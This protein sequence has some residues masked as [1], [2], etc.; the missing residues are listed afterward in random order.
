MESESRIGPVLGHLAWLAEK[1]PS[2]VN[3]ERAYDAAILTYNAAAM[4]QWRFVAPVSYADVISVKWIRAEAADAI[5]KLVTLSEQAVAKAKKCNRDQ[6]KRLRAQLVTEINKVIGVVAR[7]M[8]IAVP[9]PSRMLELESSPN[10]RELLDEL[11][12]AHA[13]QYAAAIKEGRLRAEKREVGPDAALREAVAGLIYIHDDA[14]EA[15]MS[16]GLRRPLA[17]MAA[18]FFKTVVELQAEQ[19]LPAAQRKRLLGLA[20]ALVESATAAT[21]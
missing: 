20:D 2:P 8:R 15:D 7:A 4:L 6:D 17:Q 11:L 13:V 3:N 18:G 19:R 14:R 9:M 12:A 21:P 10:V 16:P 5:D 1:I